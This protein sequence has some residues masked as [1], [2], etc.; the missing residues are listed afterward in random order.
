MLPLVGK[1]N[2]VFILFL[3]FSLVSLLDNGR[4]RKKATYKKT[5]SHRVYSSEFERRHYWLRCPSNASTPL[6]FLALRTR[7]RS[8][9]SS[10]PLP[11]SSRTRPGSMYSTSS[12]G[13]KSALYTNERQTGSKGELSV[14]KSIQ[15]ESRTLL[16]EVVTEKSVRQ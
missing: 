2:I 8:Y 14:P 1:A 15:T 12:I 10:S 6:P 7:P 3:I 11:Y 9:S 4:Y 16:A 5:I 13:G